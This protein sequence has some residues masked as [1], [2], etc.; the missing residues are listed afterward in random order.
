MGVMTGHQVSRPSDGAAAA[1]PYREV[2]TVPAG[3]TTRGTSCIP[4]PASR[5]LQTTF[6]WRFTNIISTHQDALIF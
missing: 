6:A 5:E 4:H 3:N 1:A 2:S